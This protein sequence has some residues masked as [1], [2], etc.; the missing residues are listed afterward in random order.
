[1]GSVLQA[2]TDLQQLVINV[3]VPSLHMGM[4]GGDDDMDLHCGFCPLRVVF[5]DWLPLSTWDGLVVS[6]SPF[7]QKNKI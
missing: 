5:F 4:G 6:W 7:S 3:P 2:G 1:M